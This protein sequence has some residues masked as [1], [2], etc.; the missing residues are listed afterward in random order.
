MPV[1]V[2]FDAGN[3]ESIALAEAPRLPPNLRP[4]LCVDN[5]QYHVERA[6]AFLADRVGVNP[7]SLRRPSL[8]VLAGPW[9]SSIRQVPVGDV[10]VDGQWRQAAG[11]RYRVQL[12]HEQSGRT[13]RALHVECVPAG[14]PKLTRASFS[15]RGLEAGRRALESL[16]TARPAAVAGAD[17]VIAVPE[18]GSCERR[19]TD[20]NDLEVAEGAEVVRWQLSRAVDRELTPAACLEPERRGPSVARPG[21]A[22]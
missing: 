15:N 8:S 20:W 5:D 22:R 11:G 2:C 7:N 21:V 14:D 6:I 10:N 4:V 3:L 16:S 18:F 19:P 1:I 12:E 13:V 17:A 9:P